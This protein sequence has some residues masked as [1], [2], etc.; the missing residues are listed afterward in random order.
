MSE[1][2][3]RKPYP[4]VPDKEFSDGIPPIQVPA[5]TP[6]PPIAQQPK[7]LPKP[8]VS[9]VQKTDPVVTKVYLHTSKPSDRV[10]LE[11]IGDALRIKGYVIPDTRLSSS[12]TQGDVRFF[13]SQDRRD[14]ESVKSIVEVG[15]P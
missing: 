1:G 2:A 15:T 10:V 11:Q 3:N 9:A 4:E 6:E 5:P 12:K 7:P 13:F 14:A 8:S